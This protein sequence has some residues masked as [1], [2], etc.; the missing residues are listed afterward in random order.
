MNTNTEINTAA[1]LPHS[2]EAILRGRIRAVWRI[3]AAKR[4]A[5]AAQHAAYAL[6]LGMPLEK[7]FTPITNAKKLANG[8]DA[9]QGRDIAVSAALAGSLSTW[10]PFESLLEEAKLKEKWGHKSY[11][12][13]SHPLLERASK[14][15]G[16]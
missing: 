14:A 4:N 12:M 2:P 9:N 8:M 6:L 13:S 15:G 7:A 5:T 11:D 3:H 16:A 10:S 1:T